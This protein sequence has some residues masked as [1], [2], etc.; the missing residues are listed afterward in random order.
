M[1][2]V[3]GGQK[4]GGGKSCIA[5]NL[6]VWLPLNDHSAA[7]VEGDPQGTTA[8]WAAERAQNKLL[9][10]FPFELLRGN[11]QAQL[12]A[13]EA[14][15]GNVIVDMGGADS[16]HQREALLVASHFLLP[17]RPKRRDLKRLPHLE[18][19]VTEARKLNPSLV[20]RA[21]ISQAPTLPSQMSRILTA[22]EA[23]ASFGIEVIDTI[24]YNRNAYDDADE[25]GSSVLEMKD[26]P[27]AVEEISNLANELWSQ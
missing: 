8:E 20:V 16:A 21:V 2:T 24:V 26:D 3:V 6:T 4:G 7:L 27:K 1:I 15:H 18:T 22:K 5:Q 9:V 19:I 23:I 14:R 12:K 13:L 17:V 25:G 10:S 11:V